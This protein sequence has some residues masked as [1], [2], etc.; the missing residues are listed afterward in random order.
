M[1]RP[2]KWPPLPKRRHG[3]GSLARLPDGRLRARLPARLDPKRTAREFPADALPEAQAWLAA[4]LAP[5]PA[6]TTA[7]ATVRDWSGLWWANAVAP[8]HPPNTAK[9]Y[10]YALRQLEPLYGTLLADLRPSALQAVVGTLSARLAPS[11][12]TAIVGVWRRCLAAAVDDEL[13]SRNPAARLVLPRPG[14]RP[15][16]R[17]LT[18]DEA[19]RIAAAIPGHR[20]EAAFALMLG[21]G[22]RIGEILGLRWADVGDGRLRV[23][24]QFTNGH[25]RPVPKGRNPHDVPLPPFAAAALRRHR[26]AQPVGPVL[27]FASPAARPPW[28]RPWSDNTVAA[29]L[30]A[31]LVTLGIDHATPHASRHGLATYWLNRGVP[32]ATVAELLGHADPSI[33]LRAYSHSSAD[34][35]SQAGAL[36]DGLFAGVSGDLGGFGAGQPTPPIESEG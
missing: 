26:A 16:R 21:C 23:E 15:K 7:A 17:H 9:W 12:V 4:Q 1:A 5:P 2:R 6:S 30:A 32:P 29:D 13:I 19:R 33:T 10:L 35:R 28:S 3:T 22:L 14:P 18:P 36:V 31:L 34:A 25:F 24:Q 11:N 27:V 8:M 20:F